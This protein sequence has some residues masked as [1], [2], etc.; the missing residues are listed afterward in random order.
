MHQTKAP[1][2]Y[3][4]RRY[5]KTEN[6]SPKIFFATTGVP[7]ASIIRNS[8]RVITQ[9]CIPSCY[10]SGLETS[11]DPN[12]FLQGGL[13]RVPYRTPSRIIEGT[14]GMLGGQAVD[15]ITKINELTLHG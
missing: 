9:S 8:S 12:E 7:F 2:R 1:H 4:L 14:A 13:G 10:L 5:R 6:R 15:L 11:I 3:I